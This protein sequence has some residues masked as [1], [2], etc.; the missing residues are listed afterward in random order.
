MIKSSHQGKMPLSLCSLL[1]TY[2][3]KTRACMERISTVFKLPINGTVDNMRNQILAYAEKNNAEEKIRDLALQHKQIEAKNARIAA[4]QSLSQSSTSSPILS[5]PKQPPSQNTP[6]PPISPSLFSNFDEQ[7]DNEPQTPSQLHDDID[8]L[9]QMGNDL[10]LRLEQLENEREENEGGE[11]E[12]EECDTT[13]ENSEISYPSTESARQKRPLVS[14]VPINDSMWDDRELNLGNV[15]EKKAGFI[16]DESMK[17]IAAKDEQIKNLEENLK[18]ACDMNAK[19]SEYYERHVMQIS[20]EN[21]DTRELIST[22]TQELQEEKKQRHQ[23]RKDI[24]SRDQ[25]IC[26]L[27]QSIKREMKNSIQPQ[28]A[29][30]MQTA[31]SSSSSSSISSLSPDSESDSSSSSSP[32]PP[33]SPSRS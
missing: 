8:E 29:A 28:H 19:M 21:R 31:S 6:F 25:N 23:M 4:T 14:T 12:Q 32:P 26:E 13:R 15:H 20:N 27:L 1:Q 3:Y 11:N 5:T 24:E 22:L 2:P 18:K 10:T 9:M 30:T 17:I 33:P 7:C 16:I